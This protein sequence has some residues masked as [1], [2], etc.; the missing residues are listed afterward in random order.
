MT[1]HGF[2]SVISTLLNEQG[3]NRN[4]IER[5]LGHAKQNAIRATSNYA[6]HLPECKRMMQHW[7]DYSDAIAAGNKVVSVKFGQAA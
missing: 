7:P 2:R 6:E 5:Q 1:G 3:W 4:A